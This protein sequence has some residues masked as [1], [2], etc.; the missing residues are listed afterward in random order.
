MKRTILDRAIGYLS[1]KAE[2]RRIRAR[3]ERD[4]MLRAYDISKTFTTS[5]W[6]SARN[7]SANQEIKTAIEPGRNKARALAQNNPYG[8]RA[9][10]VIVSNTVGSGIMANIRGRN[11]T[12]TRRLTELW[13]QWALST[14]CDYEGRH[15]F[16]GLQSLVLR[17]TA[18]AGEGLA[19]KRMTAAGPRIHLLEPDFLATLQDT[20]PMVQGIEFG[21]DGKRVSY[22]IYKRHPGDKDATAETV[23]VPASDVSHVYRQL[24]AGQ[25]RGVT[26]A[27][28]VVEKLK[29]FED[30]QSAT[31][32]R[33]KIAACFGGFISTNG[34]DT[35]SLDA[36]QLK[37]RREQEMAMQPGTW[38]YLDPGEEV[39]MASPPGVD[40]YSDF[41]RETLR[42]VAAGWGIS[43]EALTGD[44]SQSNYSSSRM[45]ML[46]FR[47]NIESWRWNM[48]IPQFCDW[49]FYNVFLPWA[50]LNGVSV[51]GATVDWVPPA[52]QHIDPIKEGEALKRDVRNGFKSW[53]EAVREMGRDPELVIQEVSEWNQRFDSLKVAFDT[54]PRRMT[55]VGLAQQGESL[56]LL[57]P[58]AEHLQPQ[59]PSN[60]DVNTNEETQED[61]PGGSNQ[62]G[63]E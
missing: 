26:W 59:Q 27:H 58:D 21:P 18:E 54:D 1:P 24:R 16:Y 34:S 15:N 23:K 43:Y 5:D 48:L 2:T 7:S 28:A 40:G 47:R 49:A 56:S 10:D 50:A 52:F 57:S 4:L 38:K 51:E 22:A 29:D 30:Y 35:L 25:V 11:S 46:E 33:Q 32:I 42:A 12:T 41:T 63:A 61:A 39:T 6:S 8:L 53:G 20:L 9:V 60:E 45:G 19:V 31:L 14:A 44:Y 3:A 62:G 55:N 37:Q 17:S 13:K 36:N